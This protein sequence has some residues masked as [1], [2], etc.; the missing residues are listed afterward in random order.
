MGADDREVRALAQEILER[1]EF[2]YWRS[3]EVDFLLAIERW[4]E[5]YLGWVQHLRIESPPLYWLFISALLLTTLALLAH[6]VLSLR[7]AL[8]LPVPDSPE[9]ELAA[10]PDWAAEAERLAAQGRFLE[11]AHQLVLGSI[12]LLVG[13][14]RIDL[15]RAEANPVLRERVRGSN[16][17]PHQ[18]SRFLGLLDAFEERWFRDRIEDDQL[19]R[20]WSDLHAELRASSG[21][22]Q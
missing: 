4:I 16:L 10:P 12:Q 6:V 18:R 21:S 3:L 7:A 19:F 17:P 5:S 9:L 20:D 14:G 22:S 13:S 1:P 2:A 15:T 8:A 11:G